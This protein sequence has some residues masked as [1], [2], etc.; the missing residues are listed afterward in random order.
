MQLDKEAFPEPEL[1]HQPAFPTVEA[2][3]AP[4]QQDQPALTAA[5]KERVVDPEGRMPGQLPNA[6]DA[7]LTDY[8]SQKRAAVE[9]VK[10]PLRTEEI[11]WAGGN[12]L[13]RWVMI[14][15]H[16]PPPEDCI[17]H[18]PPSSSLGVADFDISS[19]H[20]EIKWIS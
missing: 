11:V 8:A 16:D 1:Q 18:L 9:N 13:M 5:A 12:Q 17:S 3:P 19:Y 4:G 7:I 20:G 2:P 6:Q 15:E 10:G 14:E